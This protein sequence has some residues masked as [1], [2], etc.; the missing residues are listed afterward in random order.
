[1]FKIK[2]ERALTETLTNVIS[3][4]QYQESYPG[5]ATHQRGFTASKAVQ[6]PYQELGGS[7]RAALSTDTLASSSIC[8]LLVEAV[9]GHMDFFFNMIIFNFQKIKIICTDFSFCFLLA[10]EENTKQGH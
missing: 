3:R 2:K 10:A 4:C 9:V 1:M 7:F 5:K 8:F 6:E